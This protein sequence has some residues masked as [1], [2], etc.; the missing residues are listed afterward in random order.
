LTY[1]IDCAAA[2]EE[3]DELF[4]YLQSTA[5]V[6]DLTTNPVPVTVSTSI[7]VTLAVSGCDMIRGGDGRGIRCKTGAVPPL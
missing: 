3:V 7:Q 6:I 5:P 1:R 2:A 4:A